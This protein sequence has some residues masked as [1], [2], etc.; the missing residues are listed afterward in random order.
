MFI[1]RHLKHAAQKIRPHSSSRLHVAFIDFKQAYDTIPRYKLW[2]RLERISMPR[3]FLSAIKDMY[4]GDEYVLV[5][6]AKR[7][8]VKPSKGVKQGC[9]LSPLLFSLYINDV[10]IIADGVTGAV[11][12]DGNTHVTHMLYADDLSLCA[13]EPSQLQ[14]M[15]NRLGWYAREKD[16]IINVGKSEV[17]HFNS[18]TNSTSL[19]VFYVAGSPLAQKDCFRYL[20]MLFDKNVNLTVAADAAVQPYM[21]AMRRIY[22]F[23][24]THTLQHRPHALLWLYQVYA[25]PA[26]M[27]GSQVW[28]TRYLQEGC[29][30]DSQLQRMQLASLK[31]MLGVKKSSSNWAV[32]RECGQEPTQLYWFRAALRF[33]NA[34]VR[35]NCETLR[36]V[37][38]ADLLLSRSSNKC[39]SAQILEGFKGMPNADFFSKQLVASSPIDVQCFVDALRSRHQ[40]VWRVAQEQDPRSSLRKVNAYQHWFSIPFWSH[41]GR[42]KKFVAIPNYLCLDMPRQVMRNVS[43]FRLR[44]HNLKVETSRWEHQGHQQHSNLCDKCSSGDIQ[45]E[46]HILFFCSCDRACAL[47]REYEDLFSDTLIPLLHFS[48]AQAHLPF[49]SHSIHKDSIENEDLHRFMSQGKVRLCKF[50]SELLSIYDN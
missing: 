12:G 18:K 40:S 26:G 34:S 6:G 3:A 24:H 22:D 48:G 39:W 1:V 10:D 16:L 21:A 9:P 38:K 14:T 35:S 29:E 50:I 33:F 23:V 28:G 15:L 32:L 19:P 31:R 4:D 2:E 7:A 42:K 20:G 30:F 11:A 45:D 8:R 17:V 36:K 49:L 13:N 27:Y 43:R 44:A 46:K 37:M 41:Q 25:V 47:R 5:D